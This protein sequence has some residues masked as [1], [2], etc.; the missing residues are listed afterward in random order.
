VKK[1]IQNINISKSFKVEKVKERISK[2]QSTMESFEYDEVINPLS[3]SFKNMYMI[4]K[5]NG[6]RID[7]NG[8]NVVFSACFNGDSVDAVAAVVDDD[9]HSYDSDDVCS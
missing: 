9:V 5:S 4:L 8:D 6:N 7:Y 1:K 3:I 2:L